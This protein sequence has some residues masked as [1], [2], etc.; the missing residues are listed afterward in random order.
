[1]RVGKGGFFAAVRQAP[2]PR[3]LF[4]TE[5]P[6][7]AREGSSLKRLEGEKWRRID[8]V[9]DDGGISP[10]G[11]VIESAAERHLSK[12]GL[13]LPSAEHGGPRRCQRHE[14]HP[15]RQCRAR[16]TLPCASAG[17]PRCFPVIAQPIRGDAGAIVSPSFPAFEPT[18]SRVAAR[19]QTE[20]AHGRCRR[21]NRKRDRG[22]LT[23]GKQ[24]E[25]K[26]ERR[27]FRFVLRRLRPERLSASRAEA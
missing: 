24:S 27:W 20:N 13:W 3:R 10:A 1:M 12:A 6:D 15:L 23:G 9:D 19:M 17:F 5:E 11:D 4:P 22:R 21:K 14:D 7:A 25:R 2:V 18:F 8:A 26:R 16:V